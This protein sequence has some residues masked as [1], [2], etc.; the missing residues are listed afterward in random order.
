MSLYQIC[1]LFDN[2]ICTCAELQYKIELYGAWR[3]DIEGAPS[4]LTTTL[5]GLSEPVPNTPETHAP[6]RDSTHPIS[7]VSLLPYLTRLNTLRALEHN[8]R[9]LCFPA[10]SQRVPVP[11]RATYVYELSGGYFI[12]GSDQTT[13]SP[14]HT[15]MAGDGW[16]SPDIMNKT[17]QLNFLRLPHLVHDAEPTA[18][19]GKDRAEGQNELAWTHLPLPFPIADFG[20]DVSQDLLVLMQRHR[21]AYS[22]CLHL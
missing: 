12:L 15:A 4:V 8:W 7:S 1:R 16:V 18:S 20:I 10:P 17:M 19:K 21:Y 22:V 13:Q 14:D 3:R 11:F 2:I 9:G 6:F 5:E